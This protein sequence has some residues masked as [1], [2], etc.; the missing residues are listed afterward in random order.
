MPTKPSEPTDPPI[1]LQRLGSVL[2]DLRKAAGMTQADLV[3]RTGI[4]RDTL[5]R[6]ENGGSAETAIVQRLA[7]TLGHELALQ[8]R[9]LRAADVRS[10]FAH[11][12]TDDD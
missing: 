7:Q 5:S 2:R 12:H 11:L 1:A 4:S 8:P 9:P 3:S 10:R 6:I